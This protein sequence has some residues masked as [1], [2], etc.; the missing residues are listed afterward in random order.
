MY[1]RLTTFEVPSD[2]LDEATRYAQEQIL[3]QLWQMD[4]FKGTF[5]IGDRQ[6]GR[7]RGTFLWESEEALR[8]SAEAV[9]GLRSSLAEDIGG[10]VVSV[11]EYEV[12]LF[13]LSLLP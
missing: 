6:S 10:E 8:D 11:E 13:Q 1:A 4:G 5:L 7:L 12:S 3:P 9:S 2:R